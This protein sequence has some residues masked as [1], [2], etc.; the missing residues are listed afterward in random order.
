MRP[1]KVGCWVFRP[2]PSSH[3]NNGKIG[4]ALGVSNE[5]SMWPSHV[6]SLFS[7]S[8][9]E[10]A[11]LQLSGYPGLQWKGVVMSCRVFLTIV[12]ESTTEPE[13]IHG[14]TAEWYTWVCI[15]VSLFACLVLSSSCRQRGAAVSSRANRRAAPPCQSTYSVPDRDLDA[16]AWL[17]AKST[18]AQELV[19]LL[20]LHTFSSHG[21]L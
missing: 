7:R 14:K 13:E 21:T 17:T 2:S 8:C 20:S 18:T 6:W 10:N 5:R 3:L 1:C 4:E 12:Y 16:W 11:L 9:G 15:P 19:K